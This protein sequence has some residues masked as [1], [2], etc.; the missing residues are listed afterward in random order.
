MDT[1]ATVRCSNADCD[2]AT[3]DKCVEGLELTACSHYGQ[4]AAPIVQPEE[5]DGAT[6]DIQRTKPVVQ[7]LAANT[8]GI[9]EAAAV[10]RS[11]PSRLLAIIG[12][13]DSGKT[14][15]IASVY[16]LF[17][18]GSIGDVLFARS[19]TLQAFEETC[20]DARATSNRGT[21]HSE[22]TK[23]GEVRF[24]HLDI[25]RAPG[26]PTLTLLLGDRKGEE[27]DNALDNDQDSAFPEVDSADSVTILVDGAKLG[28]SKARNIVLSRTPMLVRLLDERRNTND[29]QHLALVLTKLD[30][31][32]ASPHRDRIFEDFHSLGNDIDRNYGRLFASFQRFE[33]AASPKTPDVPRATGVP[34]L[35][36]FWQEPQKQPTTTLPVPARQT[37]M[38]SRLLP[39][40]EVI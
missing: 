33:V 10:R 14:S 13:H 24:Y 18:I 9:D 26:G 4:E 20:H 8:L 23:N 28:D 22:R 12:A 3:T 11:R 5:G 15:L 1:T 27:Y 7:L 16:E 17:Q 19:I 31:V 29:R 40:P 38:I 37:R 39:L 34:E 21:P 36:A 35:F 6:A 32:V 30:H 2:V 25:T